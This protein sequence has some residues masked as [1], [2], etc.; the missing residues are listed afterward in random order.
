MKEVLTLDEGTIRIGIWLVEDA[1]S[2]VELLFGD[3]AYE[4]PCARGSVTADLAERV[5]RALISAAQ[6]A[7]NRARS[8]R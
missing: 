4:E 5:G 1:E 3:V 6:E 7:R 2:P 8:G